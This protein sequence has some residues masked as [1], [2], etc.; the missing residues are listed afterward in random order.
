MLIGCHIST[1]GSLVKM[2]KSAIKLEINTFQYFTRSPRGGSSRK[3]LNDEISEY[4]EILKESDIK[5]V[6][7]H[8]PYTVNLASS[9]KRTRNF[10]NQILYEDLRRSDLI[11][12]NFLV[13][14]PG[15]HV[16]N[17]VEDGIDFIADGLNYALSNYKGDT[18]IC[19]ET[20]SG[21]GTEI[22]RSLDEIVTILDKTNWHEKIG[23]CL[24]S[25]HL[26]ATGYDF[27]DKQ[28]VR[29][30][31]KEID[32]KIGLDRVHVTHINDS[33]ESLASNKDRHANI[34]KG[35]LGIEGIKNYLS[36]SYISNLPILL[37]TPVKN[38]ADYLEEIKI[39]KGL[40]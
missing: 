25:C 3:Y 11:N 31:V 22:G 20:M 12:T 9:T 7:A 1:K 32:Q 4:K 29:R 37:E 19:L 35:L 27:R 38:E 14:H 40:I 36:N 39:I 30:L 33:K 16:K 5:S 17:T 34:G 18:K 13:M 2:I 24:D 10:G 28:E 15:S 8:L 6:V 21:K 26:F 23:I